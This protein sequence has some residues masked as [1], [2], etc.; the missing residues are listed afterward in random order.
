MKFAIG[1]QLADPD[2]G[3]ESIVDLVADYREHVAEVYFPWAFL[4]SGRA[5]LT[6]RFARRRPWCWCWP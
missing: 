3:P 5:A 2:E 6:A 1:Y 4:P